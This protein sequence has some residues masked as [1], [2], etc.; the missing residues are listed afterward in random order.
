MN[1]VKLQTAYMEN[2]SLMTIIPYTHLFNML[3]YLQKIYYAKHMFMAPTNIHWSHRDQFGS[4]SDW[5]DCSLSEQMNMLNI[6]KLI[7]IDEE[8]LFGYNNH[9]DCSIL[10]NLFYSIVFLLRI[11]SFITI[12]TY[13]KKTD[14]R[15]LDA[16]RHFWSFCQCI[17]ELFFPSHTLA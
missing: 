12:V 14:Q 2:I 3:Q 1:L 8:I 5:I 4:R 15:F 10:Q 9:V 7:G 13:I 6:G 16:L 11:V 17:Q